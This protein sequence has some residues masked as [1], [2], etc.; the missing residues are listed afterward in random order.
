MMTGR[1]R[2][3]TMSAAF[4]KSKMGTQNVSSL[5][6]SATAKKAAEALVKQFPD[7]EFTS[8]KRDLD[9]QAQAM[10]ANVTANRNW[11]KET[12]ASSAASKAC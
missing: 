12:Y 6:L 4:R 3:A 9:E 10:A 5:G 11:I 1:N 7:V 2:G 8:G